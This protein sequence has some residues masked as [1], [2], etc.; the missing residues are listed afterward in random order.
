MV[1]PKRSRDPRYDTVEQ[2]DALIAK[3]ERRAAPLREKL[4]P[5][6]RDL[7]VLRKL[8]Q[9]KLAGKAGGKARRKSKHDVEKALRIYDEYGG[10][11]ALKHTV[12][13]TG[14]PTRTMSRILAARQE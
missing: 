8:R 1:A 4:V 11:G 3:L 5:L 2:I 12:E 14:I 9:T 6:E 7:A 13:A 10:R